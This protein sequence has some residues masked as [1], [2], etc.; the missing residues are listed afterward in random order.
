MAAVAAA[1]AEVPSVVGEDM[2]VKII[3]ILQQVV[4]VVRVDIV[5]MLHL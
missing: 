4:K 5:R 3:D 1:V 2:L